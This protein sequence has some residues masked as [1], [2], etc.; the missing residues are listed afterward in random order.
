[1]TEFYELPRRN[2]HQTRHPRNT[3]AHQR[4]PREGRV[5]ITTSPPSFGRLRN[6]MDRGSFL[7]RLSVAKT[8]R[9]DHCDE[10]S[11]V[12]CGCRVK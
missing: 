8:A 12:V 4:N 7:Q 11:L 3:V 6:E 10:S 1:M 2:S 5:L 9:S